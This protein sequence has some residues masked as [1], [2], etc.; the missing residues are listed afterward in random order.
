MPAGA[1]TPAWRSP[2]GARWLPAG[3]RE[4]GSSRRSQDSE[5]PPLPA[6][7]S[8]GRVESVPEKFV[9]R[10]LLVKEFFPTLPVCLSY[11]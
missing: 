5:G 3:R 2:P 1:G 7:A 10:G 8:E 6:V 11:F 4:R 9:H